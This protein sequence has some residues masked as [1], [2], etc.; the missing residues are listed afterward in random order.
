MLED[1]G[2]EVREAVL[3]RPT[4]GRESLDKHPPKLLTS[5]S[6]SLPSTPTGPA[7]STID[8][9]LSKVT[10]KRHQ[11]AGAELNTADTSTKT[12]LLNNARFHI[13]AVFGHYRQQLAAGRE[14]A[15]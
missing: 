3:E 5:T 13:T 9:S 12:E 15:L 2:I 10:P 11:A 7:S 4:V 8:R 6:R 1:W 14:G